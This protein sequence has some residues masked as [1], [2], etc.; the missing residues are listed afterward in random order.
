VPVIRRMIDKWA[1]HETLI[2]DAASG[3]ALISWLKAEGL[4]V[5]P[6]T[7]TKDKIQRLEEQQHVFKAG[8]LLVPEHAP[9]R[10]AYT[11]ELVRCPYGQ[12]MDQVDATTQYL[13]HIAAVMPACPIHHLVKSTPM[14]PSAQ[15]AVNL[16]RLIKKEGTNIRSLKVGRRFRGLW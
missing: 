13:A 8:H 16:E 5:V 4:R 2:E 1:P 7:P 14:T 10:A 11:D 3:S 12:Y 15:R 9:W 6:I